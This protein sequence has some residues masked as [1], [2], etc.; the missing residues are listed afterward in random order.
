MQHDDIVDVESEV[1]QCRLAVH[2]RQVKSK[3]TQVKASMIESGTQ[4]DAPAL[5]PKRAGGTQTDAPALPPKRVRGTQ[6]Q[7]IN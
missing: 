1:E 7:L 6:T 5:P 2:N 3:S 4:T